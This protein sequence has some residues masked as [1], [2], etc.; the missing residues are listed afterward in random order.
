M[1]RTRRAQ[2]MMEPTEYSRLQRLAARRGTTVSALVR[3]AVLRAYFADVDERRAAVARLQA[4]E[5][6]VGDLRELGKEMSE[7]KGAAVP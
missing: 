2:I 6:P 3:E 4:L 1:A 7:V 5:L